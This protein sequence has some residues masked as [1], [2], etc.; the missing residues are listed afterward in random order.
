MIFVLMVGALGPSVPPP[1]RPTVDVYGVDGGRSRTFGTA[2]EGARH[3]HL[4]TKW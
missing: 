4:A 1:R 3:R 2:S